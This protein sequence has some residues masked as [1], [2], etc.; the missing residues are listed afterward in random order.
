MNCKESV[1][2]VLDKVPNCTVEVQV[3]HDNRNMYVTPG[4]RVLQE[5]YQIEDCSTDGF[6]DIFQV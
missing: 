6:G 2:R 5:K 4:S 1:V 3:S